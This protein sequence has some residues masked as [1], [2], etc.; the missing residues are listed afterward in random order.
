MNSNL[1]FMPVL[2]RHYDEILAL[3][4]ELVH[5]LDEMDMA[6]MLDL[7]SYSEIFHVVEVNGE[8]AAFIIAIPENTAYGNENYLWFN[9]EYSKFLY[10]DRVVISPKFHR[11]GIGA[12][13]YEQIFA[14]A[15]E[16]DA[17]RI[18]GEIDIE[19]PNPTSLAFHKTLGFQEVS[20]LSVYGGK[21]VV[22][23]QVAK[24]D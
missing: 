4:A 1:K 7:K 19:P 11:R 13:I 14:Y 5:F 10:I 2:P 16:I 23:L 20:T 12:Y 17:K 6:H 15:K 24:L 21:K 3:N 9:E 18:T 22:S 8:F